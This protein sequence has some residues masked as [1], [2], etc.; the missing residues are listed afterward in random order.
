LH[1]IPKNNIYKFEL[2][3]TVQDEFKDYKQ[4]DFFWEPKVNWTFVG[5]STN[6]D[7]LYTKVLEYYLENKDKN[8]KIKL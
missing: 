4:I 8:G 5:Y 3:T 6:K 1:I 2:K 7:K